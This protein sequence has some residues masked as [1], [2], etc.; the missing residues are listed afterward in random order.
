[1]K[2]VDYNRIVS[3]RTR[4]GVTLEVCIQLIIQLSDNQVDAAHNIVKFLST[5]DGGII[6]LKE[7]N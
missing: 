1:M 4:S 5:A 7:N 6:R 3:L 2:K